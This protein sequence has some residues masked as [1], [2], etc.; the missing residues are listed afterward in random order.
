VPLLPYHGAMLLAACV[1]YQLCHGCDFFEV[2]YQI[3]QNDALYPS[4]EVGLKLPQDVHLA[5]E[6][7]RNTTIENVTDDADIQK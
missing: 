6:W 7:I 5:A 4:A 1:L 2:F 3:P